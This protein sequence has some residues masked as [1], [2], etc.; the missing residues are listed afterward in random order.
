MMCWCIG[1][2][3]QTQI[4][5]MSAV[6]HKLSPIATN[7]VT[8]DSSQTRFINMHHLDMYRNHLASTHEARS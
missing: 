6:L 3:K 7:T 1:C 8:T 4:F 5:N 2:R